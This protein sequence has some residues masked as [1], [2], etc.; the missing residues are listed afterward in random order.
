MP[1]RLMRH[2]RHSKDCRSAT[3]AKR[4]ERGPYMDAQNLY[5]NANDSYLLRG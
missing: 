5:R 1:P 3:R 4:A 2:Y